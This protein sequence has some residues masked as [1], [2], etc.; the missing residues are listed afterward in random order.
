M[1]DPPPLDLMRPARSSSF[2]SKLNHRES[3]PSCGAREATENGCAPELSWLTWKRWGWV[4]RAVTIA[5]TQVFPDFGYEVSQTVRP[6][7]A[8]LRGAPMPTTNA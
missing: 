7:T 6:V 1:S 2:S 8:I 3:S 5:R 4:D